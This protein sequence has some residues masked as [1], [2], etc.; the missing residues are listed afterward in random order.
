MKAYAIAVLII[1]SWILTMNAAPASALGFNTG[2]FYRYRWDYGVSKQR[3]QGWNGSVSHF[4]KRRAVRPLRSHRPRP[5]PGLRSLPQ[6]SIRRQ[7]KRV[8]LI[9]TFA[10]YPSVSRHSRPPET[11][12]QSSHLPLHAM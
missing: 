10:S 5:Q 6:P 12:P 1:G 3:T 11:P 8:P 7:A 9:V 2:M 4:K